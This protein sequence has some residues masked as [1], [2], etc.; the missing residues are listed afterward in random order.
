MSNLIVNIQCDNK[1]I[2]DAISEIRLVINSSELSNYILNFKNQYG[3]RHFLQSDKSN[4]WH[5][6]QFISGSELGSSSD[7]AWDSV[8]SFFSSTTE[9]IGYT[10]GK[11]KTIYLN[12]KYM[13]RDLPSICNTLIHEYCHLVGMSHSFFQS[14]EWPQTAP[15]AIGC[16]TQYLIEKRLGHQ[17]TEPFFPKASLIKRIIHSLK[18]IF[19]I[20]NST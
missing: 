10:D 16:Y 9:I 11:Q 13:D 12:D 15:Y 2:N 4:K 19:P 20:K 6:N 18:H 3:S 7:N 8:I 1:I 14:N 5:Y 17:T